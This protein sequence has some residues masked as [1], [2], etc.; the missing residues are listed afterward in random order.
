[1]NILSLT[2]AALLQKHFQ[3]KL[4]RK[5]TLPED[6]FKQL[7]ECAVQSEDITRQ[8]ADILKQQLENI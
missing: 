6:I 8:Q 5:A 7:L 3:D 1:M 4:K 2:L